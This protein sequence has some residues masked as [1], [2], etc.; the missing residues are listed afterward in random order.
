M[1]DLAN[2]PPFPA[3]AEQA[4]K[5]AELLKLLGN[6]QRLMISCLLAEGA[7]AVSEIEARLGIRQ[8]SLSQQLGALREAG[9]IQGRREAKAVIYQLS[10]P[11]IAT[12][13]AA[14]YGIFCPEGARFSAP[15]ILPDGGGKGVDSASDPARPA[16]NLAGVAAF[17]RLGTAER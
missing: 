7:F 11:Q 3:L 10:N 1:S 12:L 15:G 2:S 9:V 17:A 4:E 13:L 14:L 16:F 6:P 5:V 8:P